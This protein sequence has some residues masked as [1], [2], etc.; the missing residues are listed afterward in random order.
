MYIV[1]IC[2]YTTYFMASEGDVSHMFSRANTR[3][4]EEHHSLHT[5]SF[6]HLYMV[7][8][9]HI[10]VQCTASCI[11]YTLCESHEQYIT[12]MFN[13]QLP[14][15]IVWITQTI[16]YIDVQWYIV[17]IIILPYIESDVQC[18]VSCTLCESHEQYP[19]DAQ[20]FTLHKHNDIQ[21]TAICI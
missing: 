20:C 15:H 8:M 9:L 5:A 1:P 19:I 12:L 6:L 14:I 16:P 3:W 2:L 11:V 18:T 7:T 10:D 17:W 13:V 4:L 21:W